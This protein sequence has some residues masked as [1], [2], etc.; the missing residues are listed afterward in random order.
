MERAA[1][2]FAELA[3]GLRD[4]GN[5]PQPVA[6]FVNRLL[7]GH[8]DIGTGRPGS[9]VGVVSRFVSWDHREYL[10]EYSEDGL[11]G[12]TEQS[13]SRPEPAG[14]SGRCRCQAPD[15]L[16]CVAAYVERFAE[17][18]GRTSEA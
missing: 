16:K 4:R 2:T 13:G 17:C 1:A 5:D 12:M 14:R 18:V 8:L 7:F 10:S 15:V 11:P 3:Q 9:E 6:H